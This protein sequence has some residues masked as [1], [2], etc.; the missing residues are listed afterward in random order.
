MPSPTRQTSFFLTLVLFSLNLGGC[1]RPEPIGSPGKVSTPTENLFQDV[2]SSSGLKFKHI[3]GEE[4]HFYFTE[5]TPAGCAFFDFDGDGD[6][7]V[8]LVQSGPSAPAATVRNR[9]YCSLFRNMGDGSFKEATQGSGLDKDLGY[10]QGVAVG[11]FDNDGF[12]DLFITAFQGNHLF[13]NLQGSG[14][15]EDVTH[16]MGVDKIHDTGF[17]TSAAWGDYDGDGRLDL[18]VCYY[19]HW[20]HKLDQKCRDPKTGQLDYCPPK[21]YQP[22]SHQ[23]YHNEGT[24]LVDVSVK[25]GISKSKGRGLAVAFLDYDGDGKQDIFVANDGSASMLWKNNGNGTFSDVAGKTGSA[26]DGEGNNIAGMSVSIADYDRSGRPS[27]YISNFSGSP[28]ILFKN[29]GK[30]FTDATQIANLAFSHLKFLSFGSEFFDYDADGWPDIISNNG[31]VHH[32]AN[33][34]EANVG[35]EQAKQLL[36]NERNGQFREVTDPALLGDL[37]NPIIGRGLA[38]GDF[39]NDGRLD[40]LAMGQNASV[41][42]LRNRNFNGNHW[43]SFHTV[44]TKSNRNGVGTRLEIEQDSGKQV[45]WVQGGSSYLSSSD[46]RVYFGLGKSTAIK[47]LTILWPSGKKE[48]IKNLSADTFYTLTEGKGVSVKRLAKVSRLDAGSN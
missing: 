43:V 10:G 46:R 11:D 12:D 42:L 13:R 17:A 29:K 18:Y 35:L 27:L 19:A 23:L 33:K 39:D 32:R 9:P 14:K 1:R 41:Q 28:N 25:A 40:V 7:D 24:R 5:Q 8:F 38:T 47:R 3:K 2:A 36:H 26:F 44:G 22:I 30:Y 15:F 16:T 45:S 4:G 21:L 37:L 31:H 34:R 6:Q 20:N 48:Q